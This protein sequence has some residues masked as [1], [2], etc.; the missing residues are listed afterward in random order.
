M[1][2]VLYI[3]CFFVGFI[4]ARILSNGFSVG[5]NV[6]C[7]PNTHPPGMCP[8]G[9]PCPNCGTDSC[10]CGGSPTPTPPPPDPLKCEEVLNTLCANKRR[11]SVGNCLICA[12]T[13]Y[14]VTDACHESNNEIKSWC[15]S[16]PSPP[17]SSSETCT[18]PEFKGICI[19]D[20]SASIDPNDWFPNA[21]DFKWPLT[22]NRIQVIRTYNWK[23]MKKW[24]LWALQNNIKVLLGII[25]NEVITD[26]EKKM[27]K[28]YKNYI[29]GIVYWNEPKYNPTASAGSNILIDIFPEKPHMI[30]YSHGG[31]YDSIDNVLAVNIYGLYG[32]MCCC[33]DGE[34]SLSKDETLLNTQLPWHDNTIITNSF[35]DLINYYPTKQLW[36][37]ETGW[38][39]YAVGCSP[40]PS[41]E[42]MNCRRKIAWS[43]ITNLERFYKEFLKYDNTKPKTPEYIF[44]FCLSDTYKYPGGRKEGFGLYDVNNPPQRKF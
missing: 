4:L 14:Q 35:K 9:K 27:L 39:S 42:E 7:N 2:L 30:S 19:D 23:K 16:P 37:T 15:S 28:Q 34:C 11:E 22:N 3:L 26:D 33:G 31:N 5:G 1:K 18:N 20:Y 10:M 25:N 21:S 17:P 6:Y 32:N 40:P 36:V 24:V 29:L 38:S 12:G 44:Y 13:H 43:N 41:G 8:G